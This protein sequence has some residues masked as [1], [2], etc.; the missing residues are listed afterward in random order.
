MKIT[1]LRT[2]GAVA[3]ATLCVGALAGCGGVTVTPSPSASIA[4]TPTPLITS[5]TPTPTPSV[6][7]EEAAVRTLIG[8]TLYETQ[9]AVASDYGVQLDT[10]HQV[11]T[12]DLVDTQLQLY[13][14]YRSL[15]YKQTGHVRA[16]VRSVVQQKDAFTV[17]ACVDMSQ[18]DVVD[19]TG[20]SMIVTGGP[21]KLMHEF[22]VVNERGAYKAT[23]DA[24]VESAC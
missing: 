6:N 24:V 23:A 3:A 4:A 12:G 10:L 13:F 5:A 8:K 22:R 20:K 17:R 18:R 19:K 15:G 2:V 14:K 21:R 1:S 16:D 9:D 11:M 7:P